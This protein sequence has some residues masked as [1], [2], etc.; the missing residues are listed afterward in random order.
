MLAKKNQPIYT[1]R[2]NFQDG[3]KSNIDTD[4]NLTELLQKNIFMC[5]KMYR[6]TKAKTQWLGGDVD[7]VVMEMLTG[8]AVMPLD[9]V[10]PTQTWTV[11]GVSYEVTYAGSRTA[12]DGSIEVNMIVNGQNLGWMKQG[13]T[14]VLANGVRAGVF[15]TKSDESEFGIGVKKVLIK[16]GNIG[17]DEFEGNLQASPRNRVKGIVDP[18]TGTINLAHIAYRL[19]ANVATQT[20]IFVGSGEKLSSKMDNPRD[21]IADIQF[22]G[23]TVQENS[24]TEF[25]FMYTSTATDGVYTLDFTAK[26][27]TAGVE[28]H[29]VAI[30]AND[31]N[32]YTLGNLEGEKLVMTEGTSSTDYN[33]GLSDRF[34][35]TNSQG[36]TRIFKY[37]NFDST[38]K[39]GADKILLEDLATGDVELAYDANGKADLI[40]GGENCTLYVDTAT[41]HLT[42]DLDCDGS[43][44][45]ASVDIMNEHGGRLSL[46]KTANIITA[47]IRTLAGRIE[48]QANDEILPIDFYQDGTGITADF[49]LAQ[50][51]EAATG[52]KKGQSRYGVLGQRNPNG[53][54][55]AVYPETQEQ[56]HAV[57]KE[58][59][60]D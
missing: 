17:D 41:G 45:G 50:Y 4:G 40:V 44:N 47:R 10:A 54:M 6:I 9:N 22:D 55:S 19:L 1:W 28:Y 53:N 33:I 59:Q 32:N 3:F 25:N 29:G 12:S 26:G 34:V 38:A 18:A 5:G 43:I 8:K 24:P 57:L 13:A 37:K 60:Y 58:L 31:G 30:A 16:D 56:A 51:E 23:L 39:S 52:V 11:D 7:E 49:A 42:G 14:A 15:K 21:A 48:S 27:D 36:F 35:V 46:S 20:D 2:L